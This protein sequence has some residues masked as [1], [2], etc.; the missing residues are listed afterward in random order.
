MA[1]PILHIKDS[2]YFEVPR[3]LWRPYGELEDV[4]Q[5]LLKLQFPKEN[6]F[7]SK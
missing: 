6:P 4:P 1:S 5:W 2:Y 3:F 7:I